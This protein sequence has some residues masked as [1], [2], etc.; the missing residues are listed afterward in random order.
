M[1]SVIIINTY[2]YL[3]SEDSLKKNNRLIHH[4]RAR[5]HVH[6]AVHDYVYV[7]TYTNNVFNNNTY[8]RIS[9]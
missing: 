2:Q 9:L 4:V 8:L 7:H 1:Q 5:V 6:I 3:P